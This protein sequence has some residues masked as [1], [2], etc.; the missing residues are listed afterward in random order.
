M[1]KLFQREDCPFSQKVRTRLTELGVSFV[2]VNVPR[3]AQA[4]TELLRVSGQRKTPVLADDGRVVVGSDAIIGFLDEAFGGGAKRER[5]PQP[6][7]KTFADRPSYGMTRQLSG[8]SVTQARETIRRVLGQ[9][10]FVVLAAI[11]LGETL[12]ARAGHEVGRPYL[13]LVTQHPQLLAEAMSAEPYVGLIAPSNVIITAEGENAIVS[14][15]RPV[16]ALAAVDAG[17]IR[18]LAE[19]AEAL[20]LKAITSI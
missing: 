9:H 6:A 19:R 10:G 15:T 13:V 5:E 3:G 12:R 4:R 2:A 14:A 20:L 17:T 11:D 16:A 1:M 18:D 8:V 7:P